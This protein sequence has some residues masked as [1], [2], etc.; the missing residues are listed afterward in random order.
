MTKRTRNLF[1]LLGVLGVVVIAGLFGL[2]VFTGLNCAPNGEPIETGIDAG[3]GLSE[4]D[5]RQTEIEREAAAEIERIEIERSEAI[6][7]LDE[8]EREE[9]DRIREEGPAAVIDWLNAF[10]RERFR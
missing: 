5:D 3:P 10:D 9:Y 7:A 1:I 6:E 4:I 8:R 2:G